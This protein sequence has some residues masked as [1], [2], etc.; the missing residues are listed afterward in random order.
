[1]ESELADRMLAE[2][3]ACLERIKALPAEKVPWMG[4]GD[5]KVAA[6]VALTR[7]NEAAAA[8]SLVQ[9]TLTLQRGAGAR[10]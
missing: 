5:A 10:R 9:A 6:D 2:A 1:M 8:L 3:D 4:E 7:K